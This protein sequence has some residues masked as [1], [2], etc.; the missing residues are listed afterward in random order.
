VDYVSVSEQPLELER[1]GIAPTALFRLL[2]VGGLL[3][4]VASTLAYPGLA[5]SES[6][7]PALAFAGVLLFGV[8]ALVGAYF[9]GTRDAMRGLVIGQPGRLA[10][11]TESGAMVVAVDRRRF[12]ASEVRRV[13][14]HRVPIANQPD[15]YM[16]AV[17]FDF[18]LVELSFT[19]EIV[20]A[21]SGYILSHTLGL[22]DPVRRE[23]PMFRAYG[24]F[25]ALVILLAIFGQFGA[26]IAMVV[27]KPGSAL[28]TW[29]TLVGVVGCAALVYAVNRLTGRDTIRTFLATE[30]ELDTRRE[31]G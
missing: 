25:P 31:P 30:Y 1:S 19:D 14:V 5:E 28:E 3:G 21:E 18:G 9:V 11:E 2:V 29:P 20:A 23:R 12:P 17:V 13:E 4:A 16:L 6:E 10:V 15:R 7:A 26:A 27:T 22:G 8:L 24:V